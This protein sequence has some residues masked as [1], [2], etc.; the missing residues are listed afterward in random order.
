MKI[1]IKNKKMK[2]I[3]VFLFLFFVFLFLLVTIS[4]DRWRSKKQFK[5]YI[6]ENSSKLKKEK[7]TWILPYDKGIYFTELTIKKNDDNK[8]YYLVTWGDR[9]KPLLWYIFL[10]YSMY[11]DIPYLEHKGKN[12]ELDKQILELLK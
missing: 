6:I 1:Y 2:L 8:G 5:K 11:V 9:N 7:S 12:I 4:D 3:N 10:D